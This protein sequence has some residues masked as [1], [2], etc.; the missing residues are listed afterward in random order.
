MTVPGAIYRTIFATLCGLI[1]GLA[2]LAVIGKWTGNLILAEWLPG[3]RPMALSAAVL[4]FFTG[5]VLCGILI[6]VERLKSLQKIGND[7]LLSR[8]ARDARREGDP[9]DTRDS[10]M[11]TDPRDE[12]DK[13]RKGDP[14]DEA[15]P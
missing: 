4:F 13:R 10:R 9:R 14:R 6:Q 11:V 12:R 2:G 7:L 15:D 5:V 8:D 1:T 3:H